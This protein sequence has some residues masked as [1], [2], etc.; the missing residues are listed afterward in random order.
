MRLRTR[1]AA[2][3]L[4]LSFRTLQKWRQTGAG[5]RYAKL[6]DSVVYDTRD[7]ELFARARMRASTSDPGAEGSPDACG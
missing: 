3:V 6:G 7:L 5:P 4:G 1:Q 2:E